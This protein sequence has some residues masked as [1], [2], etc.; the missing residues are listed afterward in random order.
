MKKFLFILVGMFLLQTTY[1]AAQ[2]MTK[3]E[4]KAAKME[5]KEAKR[6]AKEEAKEMKEL[7]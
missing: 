7:Y 4:K 3:E 5:A 2:E 6:K 1:V